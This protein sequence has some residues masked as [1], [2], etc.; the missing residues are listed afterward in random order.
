MRPLIHRQLIAGTALLAFLFAT[1][2]PMLAVAHQAVDPTA[3][4]TICRVDVGVTGDASLPGAPQTKLQS[5]HCLMCLGTALPPV[6]T[7]VFQLVALIPELLLPAAR[8]PFVVHDF[9]AL[10]P[11]HPRAPPRA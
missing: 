2:F 6:T 1:A 4:A 7:P 8:S 11:L 3:Y 5:A 9:A 10:L